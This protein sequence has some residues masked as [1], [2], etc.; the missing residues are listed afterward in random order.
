[1][2]FSKYYRKSGLGT[3]FSHE[4]LFLSPIVCFCVCVCV[5]LSFQIQFLDFY[6]RA[7]LAP[8]GLTISRRLFWQHWLNSNIPVFP[9]VLPPLSSRNSKVWPR[10]RKS[11]GQQWQRQ[12]KKRTLLRSW[13]KVTTNHNLSFRSVFIDGFCKPSERV[14]DVAWSLLNHTSSEAACPR[15]SRRKNF[16]AEPL[17]HHPRRREGFSSIAARGAGKR[18]R[19]TRRSNWPRD[20]P[21]FSPDRISKIND[22]PLPAEAPVQFSLYN[23][24]QSVV[25]LRILLPPRPPPRV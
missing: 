10:S 25:T 23:S 1:M 6:S 24:R 5:C 16:P 20:V 22:W 12:C 13:W 9:Q 17:E 3:T 19:A 15:L 2:R 14:R 7:R 21:F 4:R 18:W 8:R 11:C